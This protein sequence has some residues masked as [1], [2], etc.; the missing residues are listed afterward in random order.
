MVISCGDDQGL[1]VWDMSVPKMISANIVKKTNINGIAVTRSNETEIR[2]VT[3]GTSCH[4]KVWT[5]DL[6]SPGKLVQGQ[7]VPKLV[8]QKVKISN[9]P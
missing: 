7:A 1:I 5:V 3:Y 2:F 9:D 8:G 6:K 4:F